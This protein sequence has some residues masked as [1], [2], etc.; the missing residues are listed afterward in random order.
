MREGKWVRTLWDIPTNTSTSCPSDVVPAQFE[1]NESDVG[2][3]HKLHRQHFGKSQRQLWQSQTSSPPRE[4]K[5]CVTHRPR[6]V[7]F[8]SALRSNSATLWS[9]M[10]LLF[11]FV[12]LPGPV[13]VELYK[14]DTDYIKPVFFIFFFKKIQSMALNL[15]A[16]HI[17][18]VESVQVW[19]PFILICLHYG[20]NWW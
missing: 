15:F 3:S 6:R 7:Q 10:K 11:S 5:I 14:Y 19:A 17:I 8:F 2:S 13:L 12:T 18:S 20:S 16:D 9:Q 4:A 1:Q